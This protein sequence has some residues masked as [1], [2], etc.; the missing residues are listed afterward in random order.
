MPES[1]GMAAKR[2]VNRHA[3]SALR[4]EATGVNTRRGTA[5]VNGSANTVEEQLCD[6]RSLNPERCG[7]GNGAVAE[8][9]E[10]N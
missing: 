4:G 9:Y 5:E 6:R 7:R 3:D 8:D 1:A 2:P 10:G